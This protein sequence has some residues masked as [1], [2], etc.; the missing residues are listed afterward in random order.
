MGYNAVIFTPSLFLSKGMSV[1][2]TQHALSVAPGAHVPGAF[3]WVYSLPVTSFL[4]VIIS[5]SAFY[6]EI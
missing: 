1:I 3:A 2:V 5:T 6:S 4:A